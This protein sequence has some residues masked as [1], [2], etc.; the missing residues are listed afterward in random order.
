[1]SKAFTRE[2]DALELPPLRPFP[3]LPPG[4]KNYITPEGEKHLRAELD[5][6]QLGRSRLADAGDRGQLNSLDQQI[7]RLQQILASVVVV[8]FAPSGQARFGSSVTV[9]YPSGE[10]ETFHI[11]G[12]NEIDLD[13]NRI[14]WVSPLAR[15][16][17]GARAGDT[18][19]M[20]APNGEQKLE[21][22]AAD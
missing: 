8:P 7:S 4:A 10:V 6:L 12:V 20:N 15:A 2:D 16:L 5:R 17:L 19:S 3:S 18:V 13:H 11:V 22:L 21:I 9:R 14:S 1:M